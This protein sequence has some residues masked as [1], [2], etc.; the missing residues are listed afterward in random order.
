[1]KFQN[2]STHF[3]TSLTTSCYL[4]Q[5]N[6]LDPVDSHLRLVPVVCSFGRYLKYC[7]NAQTDTECV[8]SVP[9]Q[10]SLQILMDSARSRHS[11]QLSE[12]SSSVKLVGERNKKDKLY[13]DIVKCITSKGLT[14][15]GNE[16]DTSG[17]KLVY[18]CYVIFCGT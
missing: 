13:N 8:M 4:P 15:H 9:A 5:K 17:T 7:V 18:V 10:N 16:V 2:Q 12:D 3:K 14:F 11:G 6:S 1:M